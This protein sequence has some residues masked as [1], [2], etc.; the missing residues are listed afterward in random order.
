MKQ[1]Y[2]VPMKKNGCGMEVFAEEFK[3]KNGTKRNSLE[4]RLFSIFIR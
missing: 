3:Y 1:V 4:Q 2:N